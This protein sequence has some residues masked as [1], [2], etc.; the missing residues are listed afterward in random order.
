ETHHSRALAHHESVARG[1]ERPARGGRSLVALGERLHIR[2]SADGHRRD[3]RRRSAGDD[4]VRVAVHD[5]ARRVADRVRARGARGDHA[6]IRSFRLESHGHDSR[7]D[8]G[9][10]PRDEERGD[11][12]LPPLAVAVVLVPEAAEPADAAPDDD[13]RVV[14]RI[15]LALPEPRVV[16]RLHGGGHRVLRVRIRALHFLPVHAHERVESLQ[17]TRKSNGPVRGIELRDRS[18]PRLAVEN[19]GPRR[20][21]VVSDWRHTPDAGH[22]DAPVHQ[23]PIFESRYLIASPTVRSFSA[24]SS[25]MSMLN[26][27]SNSMTSSTMSRL[28]APRSSMKLASLVSFS[29]STPS[30]F[31]MMSLT[32]AE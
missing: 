18:R 22:N 1:I 8:V 17:F 24:S 14:R 4:D 3:R 9:D 16:H 12:A 30:S 27:F 11:L 23:A 13:A 5:G 7:R 20:R 25:G 10:E 2:E 28:S 19:G 29:R 15:S 32:F 31:S 21:D 26:S 6:V